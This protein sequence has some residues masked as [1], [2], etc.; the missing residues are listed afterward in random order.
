M[1]WLNAACQAALAGHDAEQA[2][3]DA[4]AKADAFVVCVDAV[5]GA[6]TSEQMRACAL[7]V[8]PDYPLVDINE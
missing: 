2:L 7:H 8:D 1:P 5:D 6:L 4:Q 3:R